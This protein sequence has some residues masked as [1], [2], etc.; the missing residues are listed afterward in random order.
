MQVYVSQ[1]RLEQ[2]GG[3]ATFYAGSLVV[4]WKPPNND[5]GNVFTMTFGG[6]R[7]AVT[8][9]EGFGAAVSGETVDTADTGGDLN[10]GG[11]GDLALGDVPLAAPPAISAGSPAPSPSLATTRPAGFSLGKTFGGFAWG[12]LLLLV[13]IALVAALGSRRL[14]VDLLDGPTAD[15]PLE[16]DS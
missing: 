4:Y 7:V 1:P 5:A 11:G 3:S 6:A 9:G 12:W 2:Q 10:P 8:A 16:R 13:P 15:C 14:L